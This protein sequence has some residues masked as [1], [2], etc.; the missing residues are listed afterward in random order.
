[1]ARLAT[2]PPEAPTLPT[3]VVVPATLDDTFE[4]D[5]PPMGVVDG[6]QLTAPS[7][8]LQA[9]APHLPGGVDAPRLDQQCQGHGGDTMGQPALNLADQDAGLLLSKDLLSRLD[10]SQVQRIHT[11]MDRASLEDRRSTWNPMELT[12]LASGKGMHQERRP[13]AQSDPSKGE[14]EARWPSVRGGR[15]GSA[16][17][18]QGEGEVERPVGD[19]TAGGRHSSP[20]LGAPDGVQSPSRQNGASVAF[21]RPSVT[22]GRPAVPA[23]TVDQPRDT[24]DS[25]Q[26]VS[27]TTQSLL[28]ASPTGGLGGEGRG[29]EEGSRQ[30]GSGGDQEG[31]STSRAG[32]QGVG[33]SP[34]VKPADPAIGAYVRMVFGR[35]YGAWGLAFPKDKAAAGR[36]GIAIVEFTILSDG[37]V[38]NVVLVRPSGIPEFDQIAQRAVLRSAPF[39]PMPQ[40]FGASKLWRV[41]FDAKNP[42]IR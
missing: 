38:V 39:P 24:T 23:T 26:E 4:I 5:L 28:H 8:S 32:G 16:P 34:E 18:P 22:R 2:L 40:A 20:G 42:A 10:R 35:L 9:A 36:Q 33:E 27:S 14:R 19:A 15:L 25:E 12:F 29:G 17:R 11:D 6:P 1:M 7:S 3:Q 31:G 30:P 37:R 41:S 21:A 13:V